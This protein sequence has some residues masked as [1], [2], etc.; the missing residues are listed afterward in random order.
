MRD[1][2]IAQICRMKGRKRPYRNMLLYVI[3][4]DKNWLKTVVIP[5]KDAKYLK[6]RCAFTLYDYSFMKKM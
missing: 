3:I 6:Q 2:N 5:E 1:I 4:G